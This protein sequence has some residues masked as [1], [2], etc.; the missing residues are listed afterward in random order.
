MGPVV[1]KGYDYDGLFL[2]S[3][4]DTCNKVVNLDDES[5]TWHSR[6]CHVNFGSMLQLDSLILIL[7]FALLNSSKSQVCVQ[8]KKPCK[9]HRAA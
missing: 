8:S 1:G 6:L 3:L 9:P 2:L 7:K 5:N 4:S